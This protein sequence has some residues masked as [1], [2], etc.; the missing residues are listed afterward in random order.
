MIFIVPSQL[1]SHWKQIAQKQWSPESSGAPLKLQLM[2]RGLAVVAD[3]WRINSLVNSRIHHRRVLVPCDSYN[4][5]PLSSGFS[6]ASPESSDEPPEVL[7]ITLFTTPCITGELRWATRSSR[8]HPLHNTRR[9]VGSL[10]LL[11]ER[12]LVPLQEAPV[13][14]RKDLV[15]HQKT[16][17]PLLNTLV[18]SG[19][20]VFK[21]FCPGFS[22]LDILS[23]LSSF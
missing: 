2:P 8:D 21:Y 9:K 13:H 22:F 15:P 20:S 10:L 5:S 14:H 19:I 6:S 16:L 18:L 23:F 3:R 17:M 11:P 7:V 12:A 4:L 1:T